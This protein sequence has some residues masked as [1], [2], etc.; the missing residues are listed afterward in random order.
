MVDQT[1]SLSVVNSFRATYPSPEDLEPF[2]A[3]N[4]LPMLWKREVNI[5]RNN[6]YDNTCGPGRV[7][8]RM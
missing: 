1:H 7:F 6:L 3:G 4:T 2:P 8:D 5:Y